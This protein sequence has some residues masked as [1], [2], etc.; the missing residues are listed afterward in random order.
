MLSTRKTKIASE[1]PCT[2][3]HALYC[4]KIPGP[5]H[6]FTIAP[7]IYLFGQRGLS[8][9]LEG[10]M[11][12]TIHPWHFSIMFSCSEQKLYPRCRYLSVRILN[13]CVLHFGHLIYI[14]TCVLLQSI[15]SG[16]REMTINFVN[17]LREFNSK[18]KRI[19]R[20]QCIGTRT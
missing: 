1:P 14:D 10:N 17:T 20:G 9:H 16:A 12:I 2:S 8:T 13:H 11:T 5:H 6:I 15:F 3:G 18:L 19:R 4:M 7:S